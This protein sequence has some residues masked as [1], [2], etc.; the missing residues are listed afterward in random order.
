M[1]VGRVQGPYAQE[2]DVGEDA[3]VAVDR[4]SRRRHHRPPVERPAD[5]HDL[6]PGP[7]GERGGDRRAVRDAGAGEVVRQRIDESSAVLPPSRITTCPGS[8]SAAAARAIP[9]LPPPPDLPV[10]VPPATGERASAPPWTRWRRAR[11]PA[12]RGRGGPYG[13]RHRA[14]SWSSAATIRP[15]GEPV[16]DPLV[17]LL[18]E[19]QGVLDVSTTSSP[20]SRAVATISSAPAEAPP[21]QHRVAAREQPVGDGVEDLVEDRVADALAARGFDQRQ[22]TPRRSPAGARRRKTSSAAAFMAATLAAS[23]AG[24][25]PV[26]P[27]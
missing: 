12:R 11:R 5:R 9:I 3:A 6:Q 15:S 14:P 23:F 21:I 7:A 18:L 24:S 8:S 27:R 16:E 22:R 20:W 19:H 1:P 4:L 17:A 10:L 25:S 2:A 26:P 13:R